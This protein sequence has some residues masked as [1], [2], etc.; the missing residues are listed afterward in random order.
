MIPTEIPVE[1]PAV[2]PADGSP[3]PLPESPDISPGDLFIEL[4]GALFGWTNP[5][6]V[7][8]AYLV[9]ILM[10]ASWIHS[11]WTDSRRAAR[12]TVRSVM[13]VL[14]FLGR[15]PGRR[16]LALFLGLGLALVPWVGLSWFLGSFGAA[17]WRINVQHDEELLR[18]IETEHWGPLL[19]TDEAVLFAA[20]CACIPVVVFLAYAAARGRNRDIVAN[21]AGGVVAVPLALPAALLGVVTALVVAVVGGLA[22]VFQVLA[23]IYNLLPF[24]DVHEIYGA[25]FW[26]VMGAILLACVLCAIHVGGFV[27]A[28]AGTTA[29]MEEWDRSARPGPTPAPGRRSGLSGPGL[30]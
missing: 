15:T 5:V 23:W 27:L 1:L 6:V 7:A 18:R 16:T 29:V 20:V 25:D 4:L 3:P 14:R 22:G 24:G 21:V 28:V 2:L 19:G 12:G 13:G 10:L 26:P 17:V 9:S 11:V 8:L 30:S